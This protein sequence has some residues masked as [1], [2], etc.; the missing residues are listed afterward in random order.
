MG[1]TAREALP[2][3]WHIEDAMEV[4]MTLLCGEERALLVDTGYGLEDVAAFVR[5][6]TDK[7][8]TVM[9]THHHHDHA[10][11]ARWFAQTRM[12]AEDAETFL[13]HTGAQQRNRVLSQ[14]W[15]KGLSVEGDLLSAPVPPPLPLS[16][17]AIELGG[18]TAHVFRC[19]GHTPGS[20]VVWV[21]ERSLLLTGDSWNPTTWLFFPE[22]LPVDEYLQNANAL[23]TLPFDHI[24]CP[25]SHESFSRLSLETFLRG[26]TRRA[27]RNAE[28]VF[29]PHFG[30]IDTR[31]ATF[32]DGT[33]LV[34]DWAKAKRSLKKGGD[35]EPSPRPSR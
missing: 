6:L 23:L 13:L 21:P 12:F 14:A 19:P 31:E 27:L 4:C 15:V 24:L 20:A 32:F 10:L 18:M 8:L 11:G 5:T 17:S 34:F 3:V 2:G 7:P 26:A 28:P 29:I 22:A 30:H 9:L 1:F 16:E 25:H 35:D 33:R